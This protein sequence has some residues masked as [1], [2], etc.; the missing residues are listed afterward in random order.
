MP[1][2]C[3]GARALPCATIVNQEYKK[4]LPVKYIATDLASSVV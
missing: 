2:G 4:M 1:S 3:Y